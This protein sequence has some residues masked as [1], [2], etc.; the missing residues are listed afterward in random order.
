MYH[1]GL[2]VEIEKYLFHKFKTRDTKMKYSKL[3][4]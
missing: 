3:K 4:Y 2:K 1:E